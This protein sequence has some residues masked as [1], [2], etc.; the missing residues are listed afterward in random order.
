MVE[1]LLSHLAAFQRSFSSQM[2]VFEDEVASFSQPMQSG[3]LVPNPV[4]HPDSPVFLQENSSS[5]TAIVSD[6]F[7][8]NTLGF[9]EDSS[10]VPLCFPYCA[11][12]KSEGAWPVPSDP[13]EGSHLSSFSFSAIG[14][15]LASR[16]TGPE[17][18]EGVRLSLVC[19]G[20][21]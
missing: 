5:S 2:S 7:M 1:V 11:P 12:Y 15:V 21:R 20:E 9:L 17:K 14:L 8:G 13:S 16:W 18:E 4:V 10:P 3:D 19:T 6:T